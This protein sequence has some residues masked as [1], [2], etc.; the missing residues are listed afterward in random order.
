MQTQGVSEGEL[1]KE[2]VTG[3][4]EEEWVVGWQVNSSPS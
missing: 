2:K 4:A 1:I 3:E